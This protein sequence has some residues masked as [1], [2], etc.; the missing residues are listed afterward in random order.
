MESG[1]ENGTSKFN[2]ILFTRK[3]KLKMAKSLTDGEML[4]GKKHG[5]WTTYYANG[6]KRS[7]G[8][9]IHGKKEGLWIQYYKNGNKTSEASFRDGKT[10]ASIYAITRTETANGAV[11]IENMMVAPLMVEKKGSGSVTKRMAR[12]CG[13]SSPI[14]KAVLVRNRMNIHSVSVM[15]VAKVDVLHGAIPVHNAAQKWLNSQQKF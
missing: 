3:E 5:Y 15:C 4:N 2:P 10:K 1:F 8:R 13:V 7:E 12:R 9:Y 14:R 11:P 6:F